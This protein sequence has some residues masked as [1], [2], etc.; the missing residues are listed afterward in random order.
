M[1]ETHLT[2]KLSL[3]PLK[4]R[5]DNLFVKG[6]TKFSAEVILSIVTYLLIT[7]S[8]IKWYFLFMSLIFWWFLSSFDYA[9]APLLSQNNTKGNTSKGTIPSP[10][11]NFWSQMTSFSALEAT[12]YLAFIID[13]VI[14]DCFT[15]LQLTTLPPRVN[16]NPE[17]DLRESL[18]DWKSE[19]TYPKGNSSS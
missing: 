15:L 13:S 11:K 3:W 8:C 16:K 10:I 9:T 19:S 17:V 5:V 7:I 4:T 6:F 18:L 2:P 1:L 12:T 14:Q